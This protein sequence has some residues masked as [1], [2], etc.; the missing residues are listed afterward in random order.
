[1]NLLNAQKTIRVDNPL[2]FSRK[3]IVS[4]PVSQLKSFL[5]KNKE[6]NLRIKDAN[7]NPLVIQWVDY[8]GDGQNDELLFEATVEAGKKAVY[9]IVADAKPRSRIPKFLLTPGWFRKGWTI[10]PGRMTG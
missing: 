4:I 5:N 7:G 8:D 3:E 6:A 2:N 1:M 10:M 9:H